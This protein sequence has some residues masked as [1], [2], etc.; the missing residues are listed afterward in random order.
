[1]T[2][3]DVP[4]RRGELRQIAEDAMEPILAM[5]VSEAPQQAAAGDD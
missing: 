3:N 5:L 4:G 1:M 2:S